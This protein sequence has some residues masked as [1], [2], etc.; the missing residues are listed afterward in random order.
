[1]LRK[2]TGACQ[3]VI[4]NVFIVVIKCHARAASPDVCNYSFLKSFALLREGKSRL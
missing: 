2:C 4:S 3:L 1:M